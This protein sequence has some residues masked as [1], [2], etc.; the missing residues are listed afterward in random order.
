MKKNLGY[1]DNEL[2]NLKG[3]DYRMF[4]EADK[5][6]KNAK[7]KLDN[8]HANNDN[9]KYI[10]FD[11]LENA[12]TSG[13]QELGG[14]DNLLDEVD[15]SGKQMD[16]ITHGEKIAD[17]LGKVK[18]INPNLLASQLN[19]LSLR[20][21]DATIDALNNVA[22]CTAIEGV[23]V[24]QEELEALREAS[25]FHGLGEDAQEDL[26]AHKQ[27][28]VSGKP[29]GRA[30][31][32]PTAGLNDDMGRM[33]LGGGATQSKP[34]SMVMDAPPRGL[35]MQQPVPRISHADPPL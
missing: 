35:A 27:P 18:T 17:I 31:A 20:F 10:A 22:K 21:E 30:G 14:E 13:N 32:R 33:N 23:E 25:A 26:F 1:V 4:D 11:M 24:S 12:K 28:S 15:Q 16:I 7:G 3:V 9:A 2:K 29:A 5:W 6:L 34:S 8:F 19:K